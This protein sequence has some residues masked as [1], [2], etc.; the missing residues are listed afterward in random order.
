MKRV[1]TFGVLLIVM[2]V[3]ILLGYAMYLFVQANSIPPVIRIGLATLFAGILVILLCLVR[4][5]WL[6]VRKGRLN[7]RGG[8]ERADSDI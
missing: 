6:D 2:G 5:R 1:E 8:E 7:K 4:E 3:L